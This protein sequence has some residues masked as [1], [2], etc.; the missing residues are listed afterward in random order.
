MFYSIL[1]SNKGL[2]PVVPRVSGPTDYTNSASCMQSVTFSFVCVAAQQSEEMSVSGE[3]REE[4]THGTKK[5]ASGNA[6]QATDTKPAVHCR[7]WVK[8]ENVLIRNSN[9]SVCE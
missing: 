3:E 8:S 9:I 4:H 5:L 1:E 6:Q 7:F 2:A